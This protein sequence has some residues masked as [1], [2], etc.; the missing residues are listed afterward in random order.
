MSSIVPRRPVFHFVAAFV[1]TALFLAVV[2]LLPSL[3]TAT[4]PQMVLKCAVE[5]IVAV[6]I[7]YALIRWGEPPRALGV[8]PVRAATV[9]WGP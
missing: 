7:L 8:R 1:S 4:N 5:I 9:G 2:T 6:A 3:K